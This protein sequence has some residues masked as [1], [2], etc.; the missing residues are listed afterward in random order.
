M[1]EAEESR[2]I[3][4]CFSSSGSRGNCVYVLSQETGAAGY[5]KTRERQCAHVEVF[6]NARGTA[7]Y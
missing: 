6:V 3:E 2:R 4:D 7:L 5:V 1:G